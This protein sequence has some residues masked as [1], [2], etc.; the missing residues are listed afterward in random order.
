LR[1]QVAKLPENP[2]PFVRTLP[3]ALNSLSTILVIKKIVTIK[4]ENL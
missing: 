2:E 4:L 3:R 1:G